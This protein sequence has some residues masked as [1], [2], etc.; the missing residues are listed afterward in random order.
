M[1]HGISALFGFLALVLSGIAS[2]AQDAR[3][4]AERT[5]RRLDLQT[6]LPRGAEPDSLRLAL[7]AELLWAVIVIALA[8][9]LYAFRDM[10]PMLGL[11]RRPTWS[12]DAG[13]A[14]DAASRAPEVTLVRA[15]ELAARGKFVE[16]MH[17]LLL[18][19]LAY[20]RERLNEQFADSLTSREILARAP[21]PPEGR[22]SLRD[23]VARV[24]WTY[25]GEREATRADYEACRASFSALAQALRGGRR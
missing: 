8:V 15:D 21:L 13:D 11:G 24:E 12:G 5:I 23:I 22:T 4:L 3:Q 6:E 16:A 20:M 10:I 25:F 1:R 19:S 17:A 7:P 9:L 14:G 2:A 18:Q